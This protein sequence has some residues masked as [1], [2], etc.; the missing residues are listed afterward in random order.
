MGHVRGGVEVNLDDEWD[1][2][3]GEERG[4]PFRMVDEGPVLHLPR[5]TFKAPST[6]RRVSVVYCFVVITG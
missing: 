6:P 1:E 4:R 2:E 5:P 3:D